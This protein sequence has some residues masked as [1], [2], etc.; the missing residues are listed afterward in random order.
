MDIPAL[1]CRVSKCLQF[2]YFPRDAAQAGCLG[3]RGSSMA[4]KKGFNVG[5]ELILLEMRQA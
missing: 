2:H 5:A 1:V 3:S 4:V